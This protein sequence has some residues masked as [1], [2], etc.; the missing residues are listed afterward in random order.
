MTQST[1]R[2]PEQL[3]RAQYFNLTT[4]RKTGVAVV[5]PLWFAEEG[6][7]IYTQT[8]AES[9][10]VKRIRNNP[11]VLLAPSTSRGKPTGP[12][13]EGTAHI[14]TDKAEQA[15][16]EAALDRKYGLQRRLFYG[17]GTFIR[18]VR[19]KQGPTVAYLAIEPA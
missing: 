14:I 12:E 9:G 6:G 17:V 1:S 13:T 10:K 4:F 11:R 18:F 5:T 19:G 8:G 2:V 7:I 16:A 15:R 3:R